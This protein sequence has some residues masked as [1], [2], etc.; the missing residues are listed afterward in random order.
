[1]IILLLS[2]VIAVVVPP[3]VL[4]LSYIIRARREIDREKSS[5]FECGF[6]P[7]RKSRIPFST[8]FFLLAVIF[9]VFDIEIILLIPLPL[10]LRGGGLV[11]CILAS[12]GFLL[13]LFFGLV[14]EWREGSLNW[15]E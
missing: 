13:I 11:R 8:R 15:R 1:M 4:G 12:G 2:G 9:L 5:V 7:K 10:G 3:L 6:D 14:H